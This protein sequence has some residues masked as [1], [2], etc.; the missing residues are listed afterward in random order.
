MY[1]YNVYTQINSISIMLKRWRMGM[2][3]QCHD[4][5]LHIVNRNI[6][7]HVINYYTNTRKVLKLH[8]MIA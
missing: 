5:I 2:E 6:K 8:K 3:D 4:T 1:L 7:I